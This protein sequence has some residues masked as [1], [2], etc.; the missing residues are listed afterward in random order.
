V[1]ALVVIPAEPVLS[2]STKLRMNSVEGAGI[3]YKHERSVNM[4]RGIAPE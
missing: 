2:P 4:H 1:A 3:H